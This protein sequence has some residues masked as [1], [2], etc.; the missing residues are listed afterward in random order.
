MGNG[1]L[2]SSANL[3]NRRS[4]VDLNDLLLTTKTEAFQPIGQE[5][6][7]MTAVKLK[8]KQSKGR[9]R[10]DISVKKKNTMKIIKRL[11]LTYNNYVQEHV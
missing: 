1:A 9:N 3:H 8:I 7:S 4:R 10:N 11:N 6:T 2:L 5:M